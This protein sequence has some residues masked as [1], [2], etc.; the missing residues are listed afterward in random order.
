MADLV[1]SRIPRETLVGLLAD[2]SDQRE[3][4]TARMPAQ[5]L[6]ELLGDPKP[7]PEPEP[8]STPPEPQQAASPAVGSSPDL[9]VRF[10]SP[11]PP[12]V[13]SHHII[14]WSFTLTILVG[15]L[16]FLLV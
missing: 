8:E 10:K 6:D 3:R 11:P 13:A 4:I 2:T 9:V 5:R 12:A 16:I 15:A 14:L 7:E 1:T